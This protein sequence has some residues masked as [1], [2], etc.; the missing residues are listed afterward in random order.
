MASIL[1]FRTR[2][3]SRDVETDKDR[4][5]NI[6]QVLRQTAA[7]IEAERAG[8]AKRYETVAAN[9]AFLAQAID[10]DEA[11][12]KSGQSVSELTGQL[13]AS[14]RRLA[15]LIRQSQIVAEL[16]VKLASSIGR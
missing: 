8:L 10:N 2:S 6:E 13:L 7:Q 1:G 5:G 9:A 11:S 12:S 4:F 16:R 14:E 15:E 3:A